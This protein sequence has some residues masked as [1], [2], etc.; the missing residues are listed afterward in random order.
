MNR[1]STSGVPELHPIPVK[2]PW[3]MIGIDFI[4]PLSPEADDGSRYILTLSDYFTK[5]VEAVPTTDKTASG[6][7]ASL[8]KVNA[9]S[10]LL[11]LYLIAYVIHRSV[12]WV[13]FKYKL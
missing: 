4:G 10:C 1:K 11:T 3:H 6:V 7:A 8:F 5:W 2:S 9:C 12:T 13:L